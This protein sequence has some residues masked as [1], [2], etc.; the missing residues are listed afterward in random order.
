M[1]MKSTEIWSMCGSQPL[2]Q[3]EERNINL[4]DIVV[5]WLS[6]KPM[7]LQSMNSRKRNGHPT[8]DT[9]DGSSPKQPPGMVLKPCK[10]PLVN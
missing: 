7:K 10:Y 1:C 2:H 9:V 5:P 4:E 3:M 8:T 6:S